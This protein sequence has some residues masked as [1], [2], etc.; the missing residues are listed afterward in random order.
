MSPIIAGKDIEKLPT[1][2]VLVKSST[3]IEAMGAGVSQYS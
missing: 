2:I 3:R 1:F